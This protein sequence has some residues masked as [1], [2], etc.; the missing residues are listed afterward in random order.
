MIFFSKYIPFDDK[1]IPG[2]SRPCIV[3]L[4][5]KPTVVYV[6]L[7]QRSYTM[8]YGVLRLSQTATVE[9]RGA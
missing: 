4:R 6:D 5:R 1:L 3:Q 7:L 8:R 9:D 2:Q